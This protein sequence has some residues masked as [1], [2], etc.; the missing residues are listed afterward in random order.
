[1]STDTA[2]DTTT[3]A[4]ALIQALLENGW[5]YT[6][7]IRS[8]PQW[9]SRIHELASPD[10]RLSL[11]AAVFPD[12]HLTAHL[13]AE[14]IRTELAPVPGWMVDLHYVPLTVAVAA[15]KAAAAP[16]RAAHTGAAVNTAL[17]LH[18]WARRP[19]VTERGRL[20]EREWQSP[21]R[22]R[23]VRWFPADRH[24]EGGWDVGREGSE[25]TQISQHTPPAV[26]I[27]LALTDVPDV[28]DEHAEHGAPTASSAVSGGGEPGHAQDLH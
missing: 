3:E 12:G 15:V 24:D 17:V 6:G 23:F 4:T 27:A 13:S 28:P 11:D 16:T 18:R 22:R 10:G 7:P 26:I 8:E 21:D 25:A 5:S 20:L 9:R 1:M 14:A 19:D 2:P